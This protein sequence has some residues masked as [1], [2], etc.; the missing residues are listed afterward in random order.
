MK[1]IDNRQKQLIQLRAQKG[2]RGHKNPS[3][4]KGKGKAGSYVPSEKSGEE[5]SV[6]VP[7]VSGPEGAAQKAQA[8]VGRNDPCPCGS[9]KKFKKCCL[10]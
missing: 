9:G 3:A 1:Q 8:K 4:F 7:E 5:K 6:P 10:K 2:L